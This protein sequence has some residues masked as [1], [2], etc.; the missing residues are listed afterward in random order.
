MLRRK[1]TLTTLVDFEE[2]TFEGY[3]EPESLVRKKSNL[4]GG[5]TMWQARLVLS[6]LNPK[7]KEA[8]ELRTSIRKGDIERADALLDSIYSGRPEAK[9][10]KATPSSSPKSTTLTTVLPPSP[11]WHKLEVS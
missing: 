3:S 8:K 10:R 7:S 9:G 11:R 2:H 6:T 1:D 5:S 4:S